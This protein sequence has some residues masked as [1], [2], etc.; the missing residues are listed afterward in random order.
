MQPEPE[1]TY[2]EVKNAIEKL[3]NCKAPGEDGIVAELLK[4]GGERLFNHIHDLIVK[5]WSKE[6]LPKEWKIGLICPIYKKGDKLECSNY[7]GITLLDTSYKVL[8]N[9]LYERMLPHAE[10]ILGDYQCGFRPGRSTIDQIFTIRQLLEKSWEHNANVHQLFIDFKQA[11]DSVDR[12]ALYAILHEFQIP[13]KLIAMMKCTLEG[14]KGRVVIG[15]WLSDMFDIE[16]G[17]KQGDGLSGVAFNI[18]LEWVVR[19][20][21]GNWK[22]TLLNT[23]RQILGFADDVD[24]LGRAVLEIKEAFLQIDSAASK[25]G[26]KINE[27]KTKYMTMARGADQTARLGQNLTL[28]QYNIEVVQSFKYLGSVLNITN[29]IDEEINMR[30][31]HAMRSY[32]GLRV[33]LS[34]SSLSRQTKFTLYKTL[35]RSIV[36]Y[37]CETWTL[38]STQEEK[39]AIF[40]RKILR[41]ILGPMQ[42]ENNVYR[43]RYNAE[44]YELYNDCSITSFIK[45]MRIRWAGHVV[46]M[47]DERVV[48]RVFDGNIQR[49]RPQGRPRKRWIENVEGD[50]QLLGVDTRSWRST[51]RDKE[52]WRAVVLSAKIPRGQSANL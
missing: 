45:S 4:Y 23:S 36:T 22:G 6:E 7:R 34:S 39:L 20:I 1:P 49:S 46:R 16:A 41:Y 14:T 33:F 38:T 44:L 18:V 3:K 40:E 48:K 26:L 42:D 2:S 43:I 30:I 9:I 50:L 47:D 51:A 13:R 8:S 5:V 11:Y 27:T 15:D 32:Y 24:V 10:R 31:V 29:N 21:G 37:G 35:I 19:Q 12:N 28:E 52:A 25:V 17:L